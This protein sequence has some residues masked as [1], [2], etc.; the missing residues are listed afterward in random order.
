M[1]HVHNGG[2][3]IDGRFDR[4]LLIFFSLPL[5]LFSFYAVSTDF[6]LARYPLR[7]FERRLFVHFLFLCI[8]MVERHYVKTSNLQAL[9]LLL[10]LLHH[11]LLKQNSF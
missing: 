10:H 6:K 3:K 1:G 8:L 9:C 4:L 2:V 11:L 5:P 7:M